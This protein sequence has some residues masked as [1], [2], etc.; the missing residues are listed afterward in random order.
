MVKG[1]EALCYSSGS[2][3][4]AVLLSAVVADLFAAWIL[5][6]PMSDQVD[7]FQIHWQRGDEFRFVAQGSVRE[8]ESRGGDALGWIRST[9]AAKRRE[10]PPGFIPAVI[11][12]DHPAMMLGGD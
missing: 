4:E 2:W 5:R 8:L 10:C 1:C 6:R 9:I 7:I 11:W 12:G 3:L